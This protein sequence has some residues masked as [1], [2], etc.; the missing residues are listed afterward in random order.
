MRAVLDAEH[1][2]EAFI[3]GYSDGATMSLL[4]AAADPER[5]AGLIVASFTASWNRTDDLP[6]QPTMEEWMRRAGQWAAA[7]GTRVSR[8]SPGAERSRRRRLCPVVRSLRTAVPDAESL[9]RSVSPSGRDRY[10][11]SAA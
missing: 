3:G 4:F 8:L 6:R 7:S 2:D 1:V 9:H 5:T 10:P 11:P